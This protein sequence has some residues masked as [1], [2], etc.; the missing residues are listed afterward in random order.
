M[1]Y[2][3]PFFCVLFFAVNK[4]YSQDPSFTQFYSNPIY[5]N[6]AFAGSNGC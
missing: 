6:P 5:L 2:I 1:R 3:I 4:A